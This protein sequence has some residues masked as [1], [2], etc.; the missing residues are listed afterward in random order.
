MGRRVRVGFDSELRHNDI[1]KDERP[2]S[3]GTY[4]CKLNKLVVIYTALQLIQNQAVKKE[5]CLCYL[6]TSHLSWKIYAS[7]VESRVIDCLEG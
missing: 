7:L 3:L 4:V 6:L 5:S 1:V 2:L